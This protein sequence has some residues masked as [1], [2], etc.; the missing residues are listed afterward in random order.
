[1]KNIILIIFV[2]IAFIACESEEQKE[3]FLRLMK[4][5]TPYKDYGGLNID[6]EGNISQDFNDAFIYVLDKVKIYKDDFKEAIYKSDN[7][8]YDDSLV[9]R[10]RTNIIY[11][12]SDIATVQGK[13]E[14]ESALAIVSER[15]INMKPT[16][17]DTVKNSGKTTDLSKIKL[18][19]FRVCSDRDVEKFI[20]SLDSLNKNEKD[21]LAYMLFTYS[22][23]ISEREHMNRD[24]FMDYYREV[25]NKQT[26][27]FD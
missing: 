4:N 1:M 9:V 17:K 24:R 3:E 14:Y 20:K 13:E 16:S 2:A 25:K 11:I 8:N 21:E 27:K 26:Y 5:S 10:I 19:D 7:R 18:V 22:G 23:L 12:V 6:S 15:D